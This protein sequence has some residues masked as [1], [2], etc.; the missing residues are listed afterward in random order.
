MYPPKNSYEPFMRTMRSFFVK[1]NH[2]GSVVREILRYTDRETHIK[3]NRHPVTCVQGLRILTLIGHQGVFKFYKILQIH[4]LEIQILTILSSCSF[5]SALH[6]VSYTPKSTIAMHS[7]SIVE[8]QSPP[9]FCNKLN[10][11]G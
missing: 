11:E 8:Q 3:T 6:Y 2:I 7:G 5:T 1:E 10:K 4:T 9:P